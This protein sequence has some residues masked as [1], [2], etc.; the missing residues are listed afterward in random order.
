MMHLDRKLHK[1]YVKI[2]K[3]LK[4]LFGLLAGLEELCGSLI[5]LI[6]YFLNDDKSVT[7]SKSLNC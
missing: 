7:K 5:Y 2:K 4:R 1:I 6:D 3:C